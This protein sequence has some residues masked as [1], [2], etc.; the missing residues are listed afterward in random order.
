M[1]FIGQISDVAIGKS[2]MYKREPFMTE[3]MEWGG[4]WREMH[5]YMTGI[6]GGLLI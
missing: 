2:D 6:I 5:T 3:S 4:M 1:D